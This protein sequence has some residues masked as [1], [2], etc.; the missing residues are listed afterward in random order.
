MWKRSGGDLL[1]PGGG[2][3]YEISPKNL[4][5]VPS[6]L[7]TVTTPGRSTC[8]VGTWAGRMPNAPVSVGTSTCF[9]LAALKNTWRVETGDGE[10]HSLT[11]GH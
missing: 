5:A 3:G 8:R 7:N 1:P 9:T 2:N 6:S 10:M 11:H 4:A